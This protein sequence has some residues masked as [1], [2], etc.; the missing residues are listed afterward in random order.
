MLH[1]YRGESVIR[2]Q[3]IARIIERWAPPAIAWEQDNVGLHAG[4][5]SSPVRGILVALD[6]VPEVVEEARRRGANLLVTHHPLLFRDVRAVTP[7]TNTGRTL[8]ALLRNNVALYVAHTNLDF[9]RGGTS[10]ALA[11]A[12]GVENPRFLEKMP[13][14][15]RKIVTFVPPG[16]VDAVAQAMADAGAGRIGDYTECS[17]RTEGT[18]TFLGGAGT[19][20]AIGRAGRREQTQ[21]VRVEMVAPSWAVGEVVAAMRHAHPYEEVAYDVY[22]IDTR[23]EGVGYGVIGDLHS[24]VVLADLLRRVKRRLHARAIRWSGDGRRKVR[25]VALCGGSGRELVESAARAGADVY[26]TADLKYHL[27]RE[28]SEGMA[29]VDAGHYETERPVVDAIV[30][31]LQNELRRL[32]SRIPV[33]VAG[34]MTNPVKIV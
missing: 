29:L 15:N 2:V 8:R 31:H 16:S 19:S 5:P 33:S 34:R 21:E 30:G 32:G 18:G 10:F 25:A 17:F 11:R 27:F 4:D 28:A 23:S 6:P 9:A 26:I 12:L 22:T 1:Y 3:E 24:P 14:V 7:A 20:P 13:G